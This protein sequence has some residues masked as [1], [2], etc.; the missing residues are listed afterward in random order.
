MV[1]CNLS[2]V[3]FSPHTVNAGDPKCSLKILIERYQQGETHAVSL[4][5]QLAQIYQFHLEIKETVTTGV[6]SGFHSE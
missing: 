2:L 1:T 6:H 3:L 5:H 4:L